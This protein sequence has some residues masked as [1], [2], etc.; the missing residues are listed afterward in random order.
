MPSIKDG[1][2]VRNRGQYLS[3]FPAKPERKIKTEKK[4]RRKKGEKTDKTKKNVK[5]KSHGFLI[6]RFFFDGFLW[7]FLGFFS[8]FLSFPLFLWSNIQRFWGQ[9]KIL[10]KRFISTGVFGF[11]Y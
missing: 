2:D 9:N 5:L 3:P 10:A 1:H 11:R 8:Y 7:V 6:S 4:K